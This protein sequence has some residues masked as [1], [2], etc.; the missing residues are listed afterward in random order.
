MIPLAPARFS[1]TTCCPSRSERC[2]PTIRAAKSTPPPGGNGTSIRTG[3]AGQACA[4]AASGAPAAR[5]IASTF[6]TVPSIIVPYR[7]PRG[8]LRR[9]DGDRARAAARL[10]DC[11]VDLRH[12]LGRHQLHRALRESRV[13]PVHARVDDLAEIADSLPE[14]QDLVDDLIHRAP[15]HEAVEDE[16]GRELRVRLVLALLEHHVTLRQGELR[17]QLVVVEA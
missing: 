11:A 9:R 16:V 3:F 14:R 15:N 6:T 13:D 8:L 2:F 17:L 10:R 7:R 5:A 4:P 1:M 12:D